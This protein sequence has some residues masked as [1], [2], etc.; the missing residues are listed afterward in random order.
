MELPSPT[1]PEFDK[2]YKTVIKYKYSLEHH[3]MLEWIDQNS[4]GTVDVKITEDSTGPFVKYDM[5]YFAFE[6]P[7]D[8]LV[9]RIKYEIS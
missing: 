2:K 1:Q 9:F 7:D 3:M 8:A 4:K 6:D 5:I